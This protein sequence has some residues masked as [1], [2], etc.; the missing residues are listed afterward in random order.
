MLA[1]E[2]ATAAARGLTSRVLQADAFVVAEAKAHVDTLVAGA[3]V[4]RLALALE[5]ARLRD[6]QAVGIAVAMHRLAVHFARVRAL[7]FTGL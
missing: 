4:A 3:V 7:L 2:A 1:G 5:F 6:E